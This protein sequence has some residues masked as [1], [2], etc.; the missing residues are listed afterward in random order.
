VG[1]IKRLNPVVI[2]TNVIISALLFGGAPAKLMALWKSRKISPHVSRQIIDEYLRVF[3]YP[4]FQL[5]AEDIHY[6]LHQEILPWFE[7]VSGKMKSHPV[8]ILDDPSDDMFIRC[9]EAANVK[10]VISGDYHLLSMKN[11][12][13]IDV[14]SPASFLKTI[15]KQM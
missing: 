12:G 2:D 10:T 11:Y 13:S 15:G 3:A 5:S 6:I 7:I 8:I 9:A 14:V 1:Q 4:K